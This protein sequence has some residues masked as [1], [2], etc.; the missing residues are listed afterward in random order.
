[1]GLSET[2]ILLL[3]IK[4][5]FHNEGRLWKIFGDEGACGDFLGD[6]VEVSVD[7]CVGG[8]SRTWAER[9]E[10]VES[11]HGLGNKTIPL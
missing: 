6:E 3:L 7:G 4:V 10:E 1:M 11:D 9:S 2:K 5:A 8:N